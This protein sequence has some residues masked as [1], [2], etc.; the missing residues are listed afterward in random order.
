MSLVNYGR[1]FGA[2]GLVCGGLAGLLF[3]LYPHVFPRHSTLQGLM[4][5]G[6]CLGSGFQRLASSLVLKPLLFYGSLAQLA[7]LR[8]WTGDLI[9][10]R[11]Y[12]M[13][14][15][16]IAVEYFL[17]SHDGASPPPLQNEESEVHTTITRRRGAGVADAE[18]GAE[19]EPGRAAGQAIAG[20]QRVDTALHDRPPGR[21]R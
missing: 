5:I 21:V 15:R 8:R 9:D 3:I 13:M 7:L 1:S 11:T 20:V 4:L 18:A 16:Q 10:E 14:A 2:G 6:A 19:E 12:R 17:G